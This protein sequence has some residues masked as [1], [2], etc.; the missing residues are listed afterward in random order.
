MVCRGR[1]LCKDK[2]C[3]TCF[4][5]SFA[6]HSRHKNWSKKNKLNPRE[7]FKVSRNIAI[8]LCDKCGHE[9][10]SKLAR[11][12]NGHWCAFCSNQKLCD[13]NECKICF[14]KSFA[15]EEYRGLWSTKNEILP[16]ELLKN[17]HK[18][19]LFDCECGHEFESKLNSVTQGCWCPYCSKPPKKICEKED[20][21][22]CFEKSFAS[23][24]KN[25][26][27]SD[28]NE[29]SSRKVFKGSDKKV[30]FKCDE[31]HEFKMQPYHVN[32][33][34]WCGSCKLK[35]ERILFEFLISKNFKV[36]RQ[37]S[38]PWC[39][40]TDTNRK[41][42]FDFFLPDFNLIIELDGNQHFRQVMNWEDPNFTRE[43]DVFKMKKC[44]ENNISIVRLYQPDVLN[45]KNNWK[46]KI[47]DNIKVHAF[48]VVIYQHDKVYEQHIEDMK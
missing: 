16:R 21:K 30:W 37:K 25:E 23:H 12:A 45:D 20:C 38:F 41:S 4:E 48:P 14:E 27:W 26:N 34:H 13:D 46:Q 10:E 2:K 22:K 33:G 35:T 31:G 18:K 47:F 32:T 8:F 11:V 43:R 1:K 29:I 9:F 19:F 36:V 39:V 44:L 24:P 17:C 42:K 40:F 3:T 6:S 5:R 15:S 7:V 28:K